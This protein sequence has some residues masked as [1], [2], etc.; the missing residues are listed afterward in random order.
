MS[1]IACLD[2]AHMSRV[3]PTARSLLLLCLYHVRCRIREAKTCLLW[4]SCA[5]GTLAASPSCIQAFSGSDLHPPA[6]GKA[7]LLAVQCFKAAPPS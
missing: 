6:L 2:S 3:G 5:W 4:L 7:A 1:V